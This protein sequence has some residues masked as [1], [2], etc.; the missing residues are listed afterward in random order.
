MRDRSP[1]VLEGPSVS[2]STNGK[3]Q[4]VLK[5]KPR[6][7]M[8]YSSRKA[9]VNLVDDAAKDD[10]SDEYDPDDE[11]EPT[12]S[13]LRDS[14]KL[15]AED[16]DLAMRDFRSSKAVSPA[17]TSGYRPAKATKVSATGQCARKKQRQAR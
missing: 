4:K 6:D 8:G 10:Q 2:A 17:R 14:Y 13:D 15:R 16:L 1:K 11:P 9:D 3:A 12:A 5:G 7:D